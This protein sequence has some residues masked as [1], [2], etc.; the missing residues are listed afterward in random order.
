MLVVPEKMETGCDMEK[1]Y[2][3]EMLEEI[4]AVLQ[5]YKDIFPMDLPPRLPLIRMGHEFKI[6]LEDDTPP[7]HRPI[8]KLS[9]LELEGTKKQI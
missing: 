6:K 2:H 3:K 1:A 7:T 5:E 4:K 9:P 8:F